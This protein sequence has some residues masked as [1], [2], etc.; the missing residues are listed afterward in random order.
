[1]IERTPVDSVP[2]VENPA[3]TT[4][5]DVAVADSEWHKIFAALEKDL[6][7]DAL[8]TGMFSIGDPWF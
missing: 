2:V 5:P 3:V 8:W 4:K 7:V 1:V 6:P